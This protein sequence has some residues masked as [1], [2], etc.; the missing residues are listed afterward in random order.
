LGVNVSLVDP[1]R[2]YIDGPAKWNS[3]DIT[4]PPAL[5]PAIIILLGMLAAPGTSMLRNIY[6]INRGYEGF[7][8][9]L[10]DIGAQIEIMHDF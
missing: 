4:C 8:E 3:A 6:S 1:H 10:N 5:R 2:V 9:R 7:A